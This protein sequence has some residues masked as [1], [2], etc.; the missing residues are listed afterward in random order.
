MSKKLFSFLK[1]WE[2][3]PS[4][5]FYIPLLP[6]AFYLAIKSKSFGFFSAVN[7]VIEG[8]GNGLESKFAT[9]KL[10]PKIFRPQTI[11]VKKNS[12]FKKVL[13]QIQQNSISYPLIIKPDIGFRGLLVKKITSK[14]A[15]EIYLKKYNSINLLIQEFVNYTN[16][17]GILYYKIPGEEKGVITSLTFKSYLKVIG[18]GKSTIL[19][20]AT[21]NDRSKH[22]IV[23]IKQLNINIL[24]KIP[25]INEEIILNYIGNHCKGTKFINANHLIDFKLTE[26]LNRIN[27]QI[28]GWYYGR[29]DL[30]YQS[31]E[32]LLEGRNFKILE[33]NG[34]I[35]EPT[36]IYDMSKGS[37]FLALSSI[38]KHWKILYKIATIN[39]KKYKIPYTN[40]SYF[41][42]LC[43]RY[44]NYT[45]HIKK[46]TSAN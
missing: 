29:I 9:V 23:N 28:P 18:D 13:L 31:F 19:E 38:K 30:K 21:V 36:H 4:S 45:K 40:L 14:K 12:H 22:Y 32:E 7:P 10:I 8:S 35:S 25:S 6:Y 1:K 2:Y 24:D 37:Y 33:I 46:L 15:L 16:E 34:I 41:L 3:W 43:N 44:F 39:H 11:F 26:V 5:Y 17:C 27:T 42:Q 20:L